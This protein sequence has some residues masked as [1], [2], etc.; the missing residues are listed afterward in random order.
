MIETEESN[1]VTGAFSFTGKYIAQRLLSMGESVRT[2]T[3]R[4][5]NENL[6]GPQVK[7]FPFNFD[8]P[9]ELT[10]SLMGANTLYNTYWIRFSQGQVTFDK[11]VENTRTLLKAAEE[12]GVRRIVHISI[13]N[14]SAD[15]TLPYFRGKALV[16]EAITQSKLSYTIIRPTVIFGFE[17][18]LINNIAWLLRRFPIFAIPGSGGYQIQPVFVEDVAEM[19]VNAGRK[20][21]NAVMDA[22]GPEI[23][24]FDEVVRLIASRINSRSRIVH[25]KPNLA[26]SLAK[27]IGYAVRDVVITRDEIDGLMSN[28]LVSQGEPTAPTRFSV[29]LGQNAGIIGTKYIS[30]LER[31]YR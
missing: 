14:P 1:V 29:W 4:P 17:G 16:E 11:A 24:S 19:A 26:Y 13:T 21:D 12:A 30:G 31:R 10:D 7:A 22:V 23:Y 3:N 5:E 25:I 18:I 20:V 9:G 27:L 2:L 6:F 15:S 28:L 8:K